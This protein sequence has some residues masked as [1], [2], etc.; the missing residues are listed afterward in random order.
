MNSTVLPEVT[1][2]E[3]LEIKDKVTSKET[4]IYKK[5]YYV[6]LLF[7]ML[8]ASNAMQWIEYSIIAHIIVRFYSVSYVAVDWT[9]MIYM[10]TYIL[11]VL[12]ARLR[13]SLRILSLTYFYS[14]VLDKYGVRVS[15]LLGAG[16]NC[17]GAWLRLFSAKP[18]GFWITFISQTIVGS[19]QIFILGMPS[20]LA[21]TWFGPEQVS[22]AC[23]AGVF[24]NQL[25]IAIGF[26]LPPM[27]VHMGTT[28]D[29]ASDLTR[30]FLTSVIANTIIFLL[31]IFS[32]PQKPLLPPSLAQLQVLEDTKETHYFQS[33]KQLLKNS[34]FILLF[35]TYGINA[36]VFY[37]VST[38]LSQVILMFHPDEQEST[39]TIGLL[40]VLAGMFG[41][42][43]CGMILDRFH[44]FRLTI[45]GVYLFST[46]GMFLFTFVVD[47]LQ[48][49]CIYASAIFLGFFMTGYLP[50]GF[51]FAVELTFPVTEGT[52][53]GLLNASAQILG[54]V[55]TLTGGFIL[56]NF[57]AFA[58]NLTFT[59][60]LVAGTL[61]T[62]T[63]I[64]SDLRRQNV[65]KVSYTLPV[66]NFLKC[67]IL[68][69]NKFNYCTSL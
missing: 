58:S 12:P 35:I 65:Q 60:F 19:S 16:G 22:T 36:G 54:I 61:L 33:L 28:D 2:E 8:S 47:F 69:L 9:S 20:R 1:K 4:H 46:L 23:A 57:S 24:G 6:L 25:G 41:S 44:Q 7:I 38:L 5:R 40:L 27:I 26:L 53:S 32:F 17:I 43:I 3:Q 49:W 18:D 56:Q 48:M 45:I 51:E 11:F 31:I 39:G 59:G 14:W 34:N 42:V 68:A 67:V 29:V 62:G 64:K 63:L 10:L 30:L 66:N 15:V 50:I 55:L 21:A 13:K 37:A 52:T